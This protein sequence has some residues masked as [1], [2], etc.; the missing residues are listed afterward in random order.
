MGKPEKVIHVDFRKRRRS[1]APSGPGL[2]TWFLV[3]VATA[4]L[5]LQLVVVAV[6]APR[7]IA[8]GFFAPAILAVS[9]A[10]APREGTPSCSMPTRSPMVGVPAITRRPVGHRS[11]LPRRRAR[12]YALVM[13]VRL[14]AA[15]VSLALAAPV[16]RSTLRFTPLR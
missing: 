9:V 1:G 6:A 5:V 8:S 2:G 11:G 4:L 15:L 10:F 12:G 3:K 7:L 14:F 13:S 16:P